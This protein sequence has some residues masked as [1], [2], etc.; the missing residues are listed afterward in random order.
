MDGHLFMDAVIT[1]H[2]SLSRRGFI[3]L[4]SVLT[5]VNAATALGAFAMGAAPVPIFLGLDVIGV[6]IAFAFSHRAADRDE[7]IQVTAAEVRVMLRTGKGDARTVWVSPTAFTRVALIG[8]AGDAGDLQLCLSD[9][10]LPVARALSRPER[11]AFAQALDQA[12][13][14]ARIGRLG[15]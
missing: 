5:V 7:R 9:R 4:I 10:E 2:R 1:P 15:V 8:D 11:L 12:I 14:R 3:V 13:M 6:A